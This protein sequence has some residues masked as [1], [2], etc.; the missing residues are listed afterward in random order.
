MGFRLPL[1]ALPWSAR[2]HADAHAVDH[3]AEETPPPIEEI[4]AAR[5]KEAEGLASRAAE[6]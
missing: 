4:A 6:S 1:D 5:Q 2:Q 3:D